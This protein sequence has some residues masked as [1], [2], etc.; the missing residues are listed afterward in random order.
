MKF[1]NI[2][3]TAFLTQ[4]IKQTSKDDT[5]LADSV[6]SGGHGQM[7]TTIYGQVCFPDIERTFTECGVI[8]QAGK[9]HIILFVARS[10]IGGA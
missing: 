2:Y 3:L 6:S 7:K 8:T 10:D 4:P 5:G 1:K 9:N